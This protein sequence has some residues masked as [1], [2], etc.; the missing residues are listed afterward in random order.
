MLHV[1]FSPTWIYIPF[2]FIVCQTGD[3]EGLYVNVKTNNL[4]VGRRHL[5]A[6]L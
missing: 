3:A 4:L 1:V 6:E 5:I 2:P